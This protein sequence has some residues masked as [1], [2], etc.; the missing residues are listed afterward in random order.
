MKQKPKLFISMQSFISTFQ[1]PH[2]GK[3]TVDILVMYLGNN[4]SKPSRTMCNWDFFC[5]CLLPAYQWWTCKM[6]R[7]QAG[8]HE[9]THTH[10]NTHMTTFSI[11]KS[12]V[13]KIT[14]I[15][16]REQKKKKINFFWARYNLWQKKGLV[17]C[18]YTHSG[19][20]YYRC[21]KLKKKWNEMKLI[22]NKQLWTKTNSVCVCV[23]Y[24]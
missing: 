12:L 23:C 7:G 8:I 5:C 22:Q 18:S 13:K 24:V 15:K 16:Q 3:W 10:K 1:W 6:K 20:H 9:H 21:F 17:F 2:F 14:M 4:N 19:H 11:Y